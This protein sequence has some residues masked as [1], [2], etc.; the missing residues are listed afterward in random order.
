MREIGYSPYPGA[1]AFQQADQDHFYGRDG[2]AAAIIEL[3]RA[4]RLTVVTGPVAGGKT[5]LLHAG[6]YPLMLGVGAELL[7]LGRASDGMTFPFAALPEHNPYTLALL[8]SWAP[9][10]APTRLAGLTISDFVRRLASRDSRPVFAAI[11]QMDDLVVDPPSGSRRVWRR[12]FLAELAR[13][14][15]EHPRLHLL[16]CGRTEAASLISAT[17]GIGARYEL[18]PLT[19]QGVIEAI[20]RPAESANRMFTDG[21]ALRLVYELQHGRIATAHGE[22]YLAASTVEPMLL[23]VVCAQLWRDLPETT[24]EITDWAVREFA[25]VD[26][27][28]ARYCATAIRQVAAEH[29]H[30][31]SRLHSWLL[32]TFITSLGTLDAA[33]E[34]ALATARMPNAVV[35][36]LVDRHLLSSEMKSATRW[37]S[38]L[39]ERLIE[40]LRHADVS[41]PAISTE[42]DY[43]RA[44][45]RDL[46]LGDVDLA[47]RHA[48]RVLAGRPGLRTRADAES[49]LGNVAH[50]QG[51]PSD[52]LPHYREAAS[53][54][55]AAGDTS[56][57]TRELAAVGQTLLA[58]GHPREAVAELQ[59]AVERGPNDLVLQIQLALALWQLGK[60]RAAVAILNDVLGVDG[61]N[62]EALRARGEILAD[63][64]EARK[65]ILDL[66]RPAI[67][68]R[69]SSRAAHGLAL[70]L[71]GDYSAA[72]KLISDAVETAPRNGRVL[73][74]A[75]RASAATGDTVH[76]GELA[77]NALDATDPPLSPPHRQQAMKLAGH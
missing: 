39:T 28:L 54:L 33:P 64:G 25:D 8:R 30:S 48:M 12:Q 47:Q 1:R 23:Q 72:A 18:P 27:V 24:Q 74:Y 77:R 43:M 10:D 17:I 6:V 52:A 59:S 70:V 75:A 14:C 66:N 50:E 20:T 26:T 71:L 36:G 9:D 53:L 37:Y 67:R 2:E 46:S 62:P 55:E 5:S 56:A 51:K 61:G 38:L 58:L 69:P 49:L 3:W 60:S 31:S 4:N 41:H 63:L 35:R 44:A 45:E 73:L 29:D 32:D 13:A 11:D 57:A 68:E 19:T 21:A 15:A 16:L 22:R 40:P 65:A 34:G 76:S 42:A 7:P